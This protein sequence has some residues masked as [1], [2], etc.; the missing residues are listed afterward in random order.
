M[1]PALQ[2]PLPIP[3]DIK[4]LIEDAILKFSSDGI[5][6]FDFALKKAGGSVVQHSKTGGITH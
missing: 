3:Q 4:N 1:L 6:K 2:H 5:R